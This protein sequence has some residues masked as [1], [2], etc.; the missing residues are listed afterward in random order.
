MHV[1]S[2]RFLIVGV[3]F[4]GPTIHRFNKKCLVAVSLVA[5][6]AG[7]EWISGDAGRLW[8]RD[9]AG[10]RVIAAMVE[11]EGNGGSGWL[12]VLV[13]GEGPEVCRGIVSELRHEL[14]VQGMRLGVVEVKGGTH[15]PTLADLLSLP[16]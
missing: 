6:R 14:V 8:A 13:A 5:E 4:L 1:E 15:P 11:G 10:S 2:V 3:L 9:D 16:S 7:C 12:S